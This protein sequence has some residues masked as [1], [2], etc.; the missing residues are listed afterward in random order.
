MINFSTQPA[1]FYNGTWA[2]PK[3]PRQVDWTYS[4]AMGY[5]SNT[6]RHL[7]DYYGRLLSWLVKGHFVDEFGRNITGGPRLGKALTHFEIYNEIDQGCHGITPQLYNDQYD[8][9]VA[10]I[11]READPQHN[12]KFVGLALDE[13][14]AI[15]KN[16][17]TILCRNHVRRPSVSV[18]I[19][20]CD[21]S[22]A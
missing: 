17:R 15:G 3:D 7:A 16:M 10:S 2:Y 12:I 5:Y 18:D 19:L 6:T 9:I 1:W 20:E 13:V 8:A 22:R 14:D 21:T 4:N 11:R